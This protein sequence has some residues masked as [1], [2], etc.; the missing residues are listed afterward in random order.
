M[1]ISPIHMVIGIAV[2]AAIMFLIRR[3]SSTAK[4]QLVNP[5]S[6]QPGPIRHPALSPELEE[7]I[8]R[9]EPVFAEVYPRTHDE[10]LDGFKRDQ[11]P[12]SEV[13]IWESIASA[14]Q[15]YFQKHALPMETRK[16]A[17]GLLLVRSGTDEQNALAGVTLVH[18]SAEDAKELMHLYSTAR[19]AA[20]GKK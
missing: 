18:L 2:I 3:Q 16:E 15:S 1:R 6:L 12:E 9:F 19:N 13:A 20:E 10:W 4:T 11:N 17:F 14:Y 8:R 7:R 5:A